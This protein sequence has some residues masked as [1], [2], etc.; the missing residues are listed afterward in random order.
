MLTRLRGCASRSGEH[1]LHGLLNYDPTKG[2]F[3]MSINEMDVRTLLDGSPICNK[4]I[5]LEG[6]LQY[7]SLAGGQRAQDFKHRRIL[8]ERI[9]GRFLSS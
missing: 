1:N 4:V 3:V 6:K 5:D 7:M 8:R 2:K 9:P